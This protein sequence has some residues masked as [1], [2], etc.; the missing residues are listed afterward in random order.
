MAKLFIET[1]FGVTPN[2]LLYDKNVSL[3]AK[4]LYAYIQGKPD[5][6]NF[7]AERIESETNDGLHSIKKSLQELEKNGYLFRNKFQNNKG[8]W[9]IE[10]HLFSSPKKSIP[11]VEIPTVEN[12]PTEIPAVDSPTSEN[13]PTYKTSINKTIIYNNNSNKEL[14]NNSNTNVSIITN[15][16]EEK[17]FKKPTIEEI[18]IYCELRSNNIDAEHFHSHYTSN[19]WMV[20]KTRMKDW[21]AAVRTWERNSKNK[22]SQNESKSKPLFGRQTAETIAANLKGWQ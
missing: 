11:T 2:E 16:R 10:Y 19:G 5:H 20:G 3:R 14:N 6:W 18:K 8:H 1:R 12:Q 7:S 21:K 13:Q 4:G 15:T 17:K 9:E 22:S